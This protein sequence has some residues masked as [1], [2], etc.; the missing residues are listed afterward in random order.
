ML[1]TTVEA[2]PTTL[3]P[4]TF[5][6]TKNGPRIGHHDEPLHDR[7]NTS[8]STTKDDTS[9]SPASPSLLQAI[10]SSGVPVTHAP[11]PRRRPRP[12]NR[13]STKAPVVNQSPTASPSFFCN[14]SCNKAV[15]ITVGSTLT[16]S[17]CLVG[18]G[19]DSMVNFC[20]GTALRPLNWYTF[21]PIQDCTA[22][23]SFTDINGGSPSPQFWVYEGSS[24]T[25]FQCVVPLGGT[26]FG[27]GTIEW[28]A[29]AGTTYV[30]PFSVG[31]GNYLISQINLSCV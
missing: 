6:P 23:L 13:G 17:F 1:S 26:F 12:N 27:D 20:P 22:T 18:S 31:G 25:N 28:S 4:V 2:Q 24:C 5:K 15:P 29:T 3:P 11:N 19:A 21:Q 10:K 8:P 30:I 7:P 9:S 14:D 16:S